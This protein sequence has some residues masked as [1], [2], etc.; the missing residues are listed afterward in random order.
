MKKLLIFFVSLV[1]FGVLF[2][3]QPAASYMIDIDDGTLYEGTAPSYMAHRHYGYWEYM[4][5]ESLNGFVEGF[6]GN[7]MLGPACSF[8][9]V[10][11]EGQ[12]TT[13][14]T[15]VTWSY[16]TTSEVA[17]VFDNVVP[18]APGEGTVSFNICRWGPDGR[19]TINIDENLDQFGSHEFS[20]AAEINAWYTIG[21]LNMEVIPGHF[22]ELTVIDETMLPKAYARSELECGIYGNFIQVPECS[23]I[24]FLSVG[25]L[26]LGLATYARRIPKRSSFNKI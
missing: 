9:I 6:G 13:G 1:L 4:W 20:F 8:K 2:T 21:C 15:N 12:P 11:E 22:E 23:S 10:P 26:G 5:M 16:T 17:L 18:S 25:I 24:I 19:K 14:Y 7:D 3:N